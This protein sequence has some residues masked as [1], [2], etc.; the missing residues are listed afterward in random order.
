MSGPDFIGIGAQKSGTSWVARVLASHPRISIP[1]KEM[2]FFDQ[3]WHRGPDWYVS[4]FQAKQG[5]LAGE[6]TPKYMYLPECCERISTT[7]PDTKLICILRNPVERAVSSYRMMRQ[8]LG[9]SRSFAECVDTTPDLIDRGRYNQQLS[10]YIS[11]F[12]EDQMLVLLFE[13]AAADPQ[14]LASQLA[15]FL[16]VDA[17]PFA[18]GQD[19]SPS[20]EPRFP[21]MRKLMTSTSHALRNRGLDGFANRA[22]SLF[23]P[24]ARR[25]LETKNRVQVDVDQRTRERIMN[26]LD[27]DKCQLEETIGRRTGWW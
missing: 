13:E 6:F 23:A 20:N 21:R 12:G 10:P 7:C 14:L 26:V 19:Q 1:A 11:K 22:S 9:E 2:H 5:N 16:D 18:L 4:R 25:F 8:R 27:D 3:Y 15:A 17:G 24:T